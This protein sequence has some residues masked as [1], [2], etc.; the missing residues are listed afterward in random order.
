M[1]RANDRETKRIGVRAACVVA[2]ALLTVA[3]LIG[4]VVVRASD[5]ALFREG[6]RRNVDI[7]TLGVSESDADG[8]ARDTI[9]YLR[10]ETDAWS[11]RV[12]LNSHA[13]PIPQAFADH[14]ASVKAGFQ[15]ARTTAILLAAIG[16]LLLL[17]VALRGRG[18]AA[19]WCALGALLPL[20]LLAVVAVWACVDFNGFWSW[21]HVNFIPDG[22][23]SAD[24]EIMALFPVGLFLDYGAPVAGLF[25]CF[26]AVA[27]AMAVAAR[28]L[29]RRGRA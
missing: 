13:M 22:L 8:F 26:M 18:F 14:M 1:T 20:L 6:I 25:G 29:A 21:L 23:F 2:A 12:T 9:A 16:L 17:A 24:T 5:A 27:A 7:A 10:G 15:A 3:A 28:R 19:G 4:A 11:P